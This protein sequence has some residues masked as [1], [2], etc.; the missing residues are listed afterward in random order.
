MYP[1]RNR[2][3]AMRVES[4]YWEAGFAWQQGHEHSVEERLG[5]ACRSVERRPNA[6]SYTGDGW[7]LTLEKKASLDSAKLAHDIFESMT[8]L[9]FAEVGRVL[10][11]S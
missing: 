11:E 6:K 2:W 3:G 4:L 7:T 9:T 8:S 1:A 5:R 10:E